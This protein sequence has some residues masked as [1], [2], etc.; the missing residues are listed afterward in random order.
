[1]PLRLSVI[2]VYLSFHFP[3]FSSLNFVVFEPLQ[4]VEGDRR[5]QE[6]EGDDES[7]TDF[8]LAS[9]C[10]KICETFSAATC[11]DSHF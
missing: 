6:D 10:D 5:D 11:S 1:M 7:F 9:G 4:R 2:M 8:Q 3:R